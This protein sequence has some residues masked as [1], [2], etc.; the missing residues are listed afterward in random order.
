MVGLRRP[1]LGDW[2]NHGIAA[3]VS[4]GPT[5]PARQERGRR[6]SVAVCCGTRHCHFEHL[7]GGRE[8]VAW[9]RMWARSSLRGNPLNQTRIGYSIPAE[10]IGDGSRFQSPIGS[11]VTRHP[12]AGAAEQLSVAGREP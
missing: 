10:E 2:G 3:L 11:G 7:G 9:S 12:G 8:R 1:P 5:V 6:N 4:R